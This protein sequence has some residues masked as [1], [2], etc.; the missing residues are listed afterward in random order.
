MNEIR[1]ILRSI[2]RMSTIVNDKKE[3]GGA[4]V[5]TNQCAVV[6][7]NGM[8]MDGIRS[9]TRMMRGH[10]P[11]LCETWRA[12]DARLILDR[13]ECQFNEENNV[14][15]KLTVNGGVC[16]L[17]LSNLTI[18][19]ARLEKHFAKFCAPS[20]TVQFVIDGT[21]VIDIVVE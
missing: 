20:Q 12:A 3:G 15:T 13:V 6:M 5:M 21:G 17:K 19:A 8:V 16:G 11:A 7:T 1:L 14:V 4:N 9:T 10:K 2:S 18:I